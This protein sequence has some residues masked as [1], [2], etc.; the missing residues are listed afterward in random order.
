M[1]LAT[2]A[3]MPRRHHDD[4]GLTLI[5]IMIAMFLFGLVMAATAPLLIKAQES[6]QTGRQNTQAK[7]LAQQR[8]EF[9]RNLPYHVSYTASTQYVD[10]LDI[11]FHDANGSGA[12]SFC[13]TQAY[14]S[15][16]G[17][18]TCT[19]A[20]TST[21]PKKTLSLPGFT[22]KVDAQFVDKDNNVI[23][24]PSTYT[25][26]VAGPDLPT[27]NSL[28]VTITESWK[29]G[30]RSK[31]AT[32]TTQIS[33]ASTGLA[34]IV[35]RV[36]NTPVSVATSVDD[37]SV[38]TT[39]ELDLGQLNLTAGLSTGATANASVQGA[40]ATYSS[41]ET[42][43]G[44]ASGFVDAPPDVTSP[45]SSTGT[46]SAGV[47]CTAFV[48]CFGPTSTSGVNGTASNGLPQVGS[49]SSQVMSSVTRSG[50]AGTRGWWLS[51]VPVNA[52]QNALL[53][54][55]VQSAASP[56]TSTSPTQLVRSV[57]GS[58][59]SGTVPSCA[60]G[61]SPT[62]SADFLTGTGFI[63]TTGSTGHSVVTCGTATSRQ[64][65]ILP[66]ATT[67]IGMIRIV[68][69]YAS[70]QCTATAAA[71]G[72]VVVRFHGTVSFTP[73]GASSA[74]VLTFAD[75]QASDPLT[76]GLLTK[77]TATG[78]VKVGLSPTGA[79]LWLG[80]YVSSWASGSLKSTTTAQ[81]ADAELTAL[82]LTTAATRDADSTGASKINL[83]V[84][85]VSCLSTDNR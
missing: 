77:S 63:T 84:G 71:S 3:A 68:L 39:A 16:T 24:P 51:N 72:S 34:Q 54:L 18:Y 59:N 52:V 25:S 31:S 38:P 43:T 62:G 78:G 57:Q 61:G 70:V 44:Q 49:A 30:T 21:D 15:A 67:D 36:R 80:D 81:N 69:D 48:A 5:E 74:T 23:I 28:K 12:N 22:E 29:S 26:Q 79:D 8:I 73:Y 11:Y 40:L 45:L 1:T 64:I 7:S 37:L 58:G 82:S 19:R 14:A 85:A 56:P 17:T 46:N 6:T 47:P 9:M 33:S 10:L 55:G 32:T 41:G 13:L 76:S 83:T 66:S 35:A 53:R 60:G 2:R 4:D 75:G 27:S 50:S 20:S 65:D 42:T